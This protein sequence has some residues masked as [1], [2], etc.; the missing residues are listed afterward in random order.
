MW[1][2][3]PEFVLF[4]SLP[5]HSRGPCLRPFR[6]GLLNSYCCLTIGP[7]GCQNAFSSHIFCAFVFS[8]YSGWCQFILVQW[9]GPLFV[10]I[11]P[12]AHQASLSITN[13]QS[14]LKL[15]SIELVMSSN[16]LILC[17]PFSSCLQSF[18][19][20]GSFPISQFF[21][22]GGQTTGAS[23]S[24]SVLPMNIQVWFPLELT[25]LMSLQFK[26][27]TSL[28][29]HHSL[30]TSIL[31]PSA[32]FRVQLSHPCMTIGKT[33]ALII[34]TFVGKVMSLLFNML[35]DWS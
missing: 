15:I 3:I 10:T 18:P 27:L 29:Q 1:I 13:T 23:A 28:L 9:L 31:W 35:S 11:W 14:L 7:F 24:A 17:H 12:A 21:A 8:C 20:S 26:G 25:G 30:K 33:I 2:A 6:D 5:E 34:W 4:T 22:S 16:H 19:A 32:S